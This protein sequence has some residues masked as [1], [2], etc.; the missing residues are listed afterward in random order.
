MNLFA[1]PGCG[2]NPLADTL[3]AYYELLLGQNMLQTASES[4]IDDNRIMFRVSFDDPDRHYSEYYAHIASNLVAAGESWGK[5]LLGD[6]RI[7]VEVDFTDTLT[8]MGGSV[9]VVYVGRNSNRNVFQQGV[10][11]EIVTGMD[12]NGDEPDARVSIGTEF[13]LEGLWFDPN[14][15]DEDS[16]IPSNRIDA[17]SAF[18]HEMGHIIAYNGFRNSSTGELPSDSMSVFDELVEARD[19]QHYFM[20]KKAQEVYGGPVPLTHERIY[21]VGNQHPRAGSDL[22]GTLM[23]GDVTRQGYRNSIARLDLAILEDLGLPVRHQQDDG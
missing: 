7:D 15:V 23:N 14:P 11:W 12:P 10:A 4:N 18:L 5:H 9:D 22:V 1:S 19:G 17:Y 21:H 13:L 16:T 6:A 20:G 3:V 2:V 8:A